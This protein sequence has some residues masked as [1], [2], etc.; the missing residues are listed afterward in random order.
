M[1]KKLSL[2]VDMIEKVKGHLHPTLSKDANK[3]CVTQV[4]HKGLVPWGTQVL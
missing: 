1:N 3:V 2:K 4:G